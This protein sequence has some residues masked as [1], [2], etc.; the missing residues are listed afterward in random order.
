MSLELVKNFISKNKI[1]LILLFFISALLFPEISFANNKDWIEATGKEFLSYINWFLAIV[2]GLLW[3][4]TQFVAMF[5]SPEWTNGSFIG[6]DK[7]LKDL[8][9]MMSNVVYTIFAFLLIWIALMNILGKWG[10]WELKQA[11]PKF[12]GWVLIVP[13][14]WLFVNAVIS[15]SSVLMI[16]VLS[17]PY[18]SF[19]NDFSKAWEIP[20]CTHFVANIWEQWIEE[21]VKCKSDADKKTL[22][23]FFKE[24]KSLNSIISIYTY[25]IMNIEENWKLFSWD[26]NSIK[27]ILDLWV[28]AVFDILFIVVYFLLMIALMMALFVRW[29]YIWMFLVLSPLFG[30][31]FFFW[32]KWGWDWVMKKFSIKEFINLALI[33]VY[34]WAALAFGLLFIIVAGQW[35]VTEDNKNKSTSWKM[36]KQVGDDD[37]LEYWWFT[38]TIKWSVWANQKPTKTFSEV[39]TWLKWPVAYLIIEIFWIVVLWIAV[40]AALKSSTVT[41][42]VIKP[43]EEFWNSV[44]QLATKAPTYAPIIPAPGGPISAAWMWAFGQTAVWNIES[45]FRWEWSKLANNLFWAW[46]ELNKTMNQ[47]RVDSWKIQSATWK[48]LQR[49]TRKWFTEM[50]NSTDQNEVNNAISDM[51]K[52]KTLKDDFK[53]DTKLSFDEK[54]KQIFNKGLTDKYKERLKKHGWDNLENFINFVNSSKYRK[55][56]Y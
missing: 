7:N 26:L 6:F 14:S 19:P 52:S 31:M 13:F 45:E 51:I 23:E 8:W 2:A 16:S 43:F 12:I 48:D 49:L 42:T 39:V 56:K 4:M 25:W 34:V 47:W 41:W 10:D 40:M 53:L 33:P 37:V 9:V 3:L 28:K 38:L 5:M 32:D 55:S 30:L 50:L 44:G 17:L 36:L 20:V 46:S 18:D 27:E 22:E 11:L 35:L 24:G 15:L 29:V 54:I 1:Y 21:A